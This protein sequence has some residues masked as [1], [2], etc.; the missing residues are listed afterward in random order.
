MK[1]EQYVRNHETGTIA[2]DS[3]NYTNEVLAIDD[4]M[5]IVHIQSH[6]DGLGQGE[7]IECKLKGYPKSIIF[8]TH[9]HTMTT[10]LDNEED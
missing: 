5:N 4:F 6:E 10:I 2:H 3:T 9:G 8:E 7:V 1:I